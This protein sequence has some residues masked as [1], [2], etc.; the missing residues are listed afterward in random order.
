MCVY[1]CTQGIAHPKMK[2]TH[3]HVIPNQ[4]RTIILFY[5]ILFYFILFY[6]I[7]FYFILFYFILFYFIS[8][9]GTQLRVFKELFKIS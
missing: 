6:F 9:F 1:V 7:L 5:F 2:F 8:L 3:S 4:T